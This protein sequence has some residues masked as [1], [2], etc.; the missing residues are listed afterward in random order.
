M[1]VTFVNKNKNVV[2]F[3]HYNFPLKIQPLKKG[4]NKFIIMQNHL[5]FL[6]FNIAY[7]LS[8]IDKL[9]IFSNIPEII[10]LS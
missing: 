6:H 7:I 2:T 8:K 1:Y 5:R 9:N 10:V 4:K 3:P